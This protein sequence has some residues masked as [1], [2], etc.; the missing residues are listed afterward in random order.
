ME[1]PQERLLRYLD[2]AHAAEVG[3]ADMLRSLIDRV[4]NPQ[5][6]TAFQEH[7]AVTQTQAQ[8][9]EQRLITLGG[10][11]S[12]G[13]GWLNSIMSKAS[14][15]LNAGHDDFDKTTQDL[16]KAYST[17]HLEVGMYTSLKA[18]AEELGDSETVALA[19]QAIGEEKQ[20]AEAIFP[21]IAETAKAALQG[22]A[23]PA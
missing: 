17:E 5:A 6:K 13:K 19:E 7:L 8:R 15:L 10:K 20:A 4:D 11:T 3:I 23:V 21:L 9:L 18:Y 14:E 1:T 12:S 2:D 16:I 22:A